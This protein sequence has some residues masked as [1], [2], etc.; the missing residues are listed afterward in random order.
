MDGWMGERLSWRALDGV[1]CLLSVGK[2]I[3][4]GWVDRWMDGGKIELVGP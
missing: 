4:N 1:W 2:W 3:R